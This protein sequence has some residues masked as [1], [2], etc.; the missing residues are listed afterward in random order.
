VGF[1]VTVALFGLMY[2]PFVPV[3]KRFFPIATLA[4]IAG[5]I[6]PLLS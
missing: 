3:S 5:A 1:G 2:M 4:G 6:T